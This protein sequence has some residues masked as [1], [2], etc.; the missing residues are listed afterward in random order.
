MKIEDKQ[1][2]LKV[3]KQTFDLMPHV[4]RGFH[5]SKYFNMKAKTE[6]YPDTA[7]RMMRYLRKDNKINYI[8]I[9]RLN[10]VYQKL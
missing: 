10:S 7:K 4:F 8:V 6:Y 5:Y 9:D 1:T 3:A 2:L